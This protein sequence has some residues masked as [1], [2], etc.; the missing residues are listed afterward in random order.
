MR[1]IDRPLS[2]Y[3]LPALVLGFIIFAATAVWFNI[4]FN[5]ETPYG[6]PVD[7]A[8]LTAHSRTWV[9]GGCA[10]WTVASNDT[11]HI[12][13][14]IAE[15]GSM[16]PDAV[17]TDNRAPAAP[18]APKAPVAPG[19]VGRPLLPSTDFCKQHPDDKVC[20]EPAR[21][22][23]PK[24]AVAE[25]EQLIAHPAGL[26]RQGHMP[27]WATTADLCHGHVPVTTEWPDTGGFTISCK[28]ATLAH[29]QRDPAKNGGS[30]PDVNP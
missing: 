4:P 16:V 5:T 11:A 1:Q 23:E 15:G 17:L 13:A 27:K 30:K 22:I 18:A 10:D 7:C 28:A 2:V 25:P 12:G 14:W 6:G 20:V 8:G 3:V 26:D 21:P 19:G 9:A 29:S 24:M